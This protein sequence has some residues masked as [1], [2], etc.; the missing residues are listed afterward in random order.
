M[1]ATR[2]GNHEISSVN[3]GAI[4]PNIRCSLWLILEARGKPPGYILPKPNIAGVR[5]RLYELS[6]D[7]FPQELWI[8]IKENS[9]LP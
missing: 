6:R 5:S 1:I 7:A 4:L 8:G 3:A 9:D 2:M